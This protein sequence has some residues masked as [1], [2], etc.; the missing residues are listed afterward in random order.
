M[1]Y[2]ISQKKYSFLIFK[3]NGIKKYRS[4]KQNKNIDVSIIC[5]LKY[6]VVYDGNMMSPIPIV[7]QDLLQYI[8]IKKENNSLQYM[9]FHYMRAILDFLIR[10]KNVFVGVCFLCEILLESKVFI[11][12]KN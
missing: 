11:D 2:S 8:V 3:I 9:Y 10:H 1:N 7:Q 4:I 5:K 12:I 6:E